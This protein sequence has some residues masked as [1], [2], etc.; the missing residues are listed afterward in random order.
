MHLLD[1]VHAIDWVIDFLPSIRHL[2]MEGWEVGGRWGDELTRIKILT[3]SNNQLGA[4]VLSYLANVLI[5][6]HVHVYDVWC[7]VTLHHTCNALS[8]SV[9]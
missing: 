9:T 2:C 3:K 6:L 8:A 4:S 1:V 5:N 7:T